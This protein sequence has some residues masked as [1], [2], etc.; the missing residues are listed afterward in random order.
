[1]RRLV[2]QGDLE[3]VVNEG[4]LS[5]Y[6]EVLARPKFSLD[7]A[8]VRVVLDRWIDQGLRAPALARTLTLPDPGDEPFLEAA[9]ASRADALVTGNRRHFPQK[10]C[11]GVRVESPGAFVQGL[12]A[13]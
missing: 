12:G 7:P 6:E 10:T 3:L 1:L 5:E 8:L 4:I 2:L 9:V 13:L 11:Q